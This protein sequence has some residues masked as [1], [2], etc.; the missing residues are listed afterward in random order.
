L[1]GVEGLVEVE[2]KGELSLKGFHRPISAYNV[3]RLT[4]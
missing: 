1:A 2:D 4:A 3:L